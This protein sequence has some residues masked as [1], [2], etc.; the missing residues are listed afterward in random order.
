MAERGIPV[1]ALARFDR[2]ESGTLAMPRQP[3]LRIAGM[4]LHVIQ[5]GN[6]RGAC[7]VTDADRMVYLAMLKESAALFGCDVHAFVLMTNH[8][9][10]LVTPRMAENVSAAMKHSGQQ[11]AQYFNRTHERTGCLWEGRFRS[12]LV[13][14]DAY[15]L[16]CQRYIELNPV[17]AGMARDP[18]EYRW[19]SFAANACG[20]PC[21]LLTPHTVYLALGKETTS[22]ARAYASLFEEAL[23][24]D[25]I[26]EIRD[27]V[28]GGYALGRKGFVATLERL[29]ERPVSRRPPGR[30]RR[31]TKS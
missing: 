22:R 10:L 11:Y 21:D 17:R 20:V 31:V 2:H 13:D 1:A 28:N 30:P 14:S 3:R 24:P 6:N 16:T 23:A 18:S 25:R 19:S 26:K 5:R 7:F 29:M 4:P 12:S 15:L 8:V 9:H 27:A